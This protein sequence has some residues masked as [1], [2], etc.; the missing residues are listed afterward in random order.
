MLDVEGADHV[1]AGFEQFQ[2]VLI[3]LLVAAKRRV[4]MRQLVDDR[5]LRAPL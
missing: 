2:H 5:H 4:G 3:A 1:D